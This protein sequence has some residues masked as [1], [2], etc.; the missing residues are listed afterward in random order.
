MFK[1][2][3]SAL[4]SLILLLC[5]VPTAG[6][7]A[8]DANGLAVTDNGVYTVA[9]FAEMPQTIEA[10]IK[11]TAAQGTRV[12][13]LLGSWYYPSDNF[14]D[15]SVNEAGNPYVH[16]RKNSSFAEE[17][18]VFSNVSVETGEWLILKIAAD[19]A[20]GQVHCYVNGE[21]KQ[22]LTT[23][24]AAAFPIAAGMSIGNNLR[25]GNGYNWRGE[26][27]SLTVSGANS[28]LAHYDL[29]GAVE[30]DT[31][32]DTVAGN[33]A[34]WEQKWMDT[35]AAVGEYD[36][37]MAIV[38][39][40]QTITLKY[41]ESLSKVYSYIKDT[42]TEKKLAYAF[43]LGDLTDTTSGVTR[44]WQS[45]TAAMNILG[46]VV[47]HTIV[48]GNHDNEAFYDQYV[49]ADVY[50]D[51]VVTKD[52][53]MKNYYREIT[54]GGT[55]YL[56]LTLDWRPDAQEQAWAAD[57]I[58]QHPHHRVIVSTHSFTE[59]TG[60]INNAG[61]TG[62]GT[63]I[64][65]NIVTKYPNVALVISG[66]AAT[67][68]VVVRTVKAENGN[69]VTHIL[70][71]AQDVDQ[72]IDG[73]AG[74]V[75]YLYF[76]NGGKDV[77]VEYYSPLRNQY[78][79]AKNQ[80]SF[81]LDLP[82]DENIPALSVSD[83]NRVEEKAFTFTPA[84]LSPYSGGKYTASNATY[85]TF[86]ETET[87]II[88]AIES[89]FH[90]YY[91]REG[92]VYTQRD[93]FTN[94]DSDG[95]TRW[96]LLWNELL[97]RKVSAAGG[98]QL[99]RKVDSLV[100]INSLGQE[101]VATDFKT[102]FSARLEDE[103]KGL[104]I[105]GFRQQT[106]GK[107]TNGY[108]KMCTT[109]AFVAIG[110]KGFTVAGGEDIVAKN[111]GDST[112]DMYNHL[113]IS[114]DDPATE[115]VEM[116]P[117]GIAVTV[118]VHGTSCDVTFYDAY[119][120]TIPLYTYTDLAV[121]FT[122]AGTFAYSVS[123]QQNSIGAVSLEIYDQ[124]GN[125]I[126]MATPSANDDKSVLR[127]YGGDILV[128]AEETNDGYLY[129]LTVDAIDGYRLNTD[130]FYLE[131]AT[132]KVVPTRTGRNTFTVLSQTGGTVTAQFEKGADAPALQAE[133]SDETETFHFSAAGLS[134]Y[135]GDKYTAVNKQYYTF[136]ET[137]TDIVNA[138][139]SKF[140]LYY[141]RESV[142]YTQ[143]DLFT[144]GDTEASRW[145]LLYN[146]YLQRTSSKTSGE[147]FRKIDSLVPL[148]SLG[149]EI[150]LQNFETTYNARFESDT[151]GAIILGFRQ[152]T[153][154][155]FVTGYY[156]MPQS[157]A[158]VAIGRS[159]ITIAG[160]SEIVA[161]SGGTSANDMYNHFET[162][163]DDP[164][165]E[166]VEMLPKD[167]KVKV[168]AV[169][170]SVK[171]W[172]YPQ[173]QTEAVYYEET[174]VPYTTAGTLA[175]AVSAVGHD[176][177]EISLTKLDENGKAVDI[178]VNE[179][180]NAFDLIYRG[181]T[182]SYTVA[183][184]E[185]EGEFAY[186]LDV[187]PNEGYALQAGSL[188]VTDADGNTVVPTRVGFREAGD[189]TQYTFTAT[190]EGVVSATFVKPTVDTPNIGNIGTSVNETLMGVRFVSRAAVTVDGANAYMTIDGETC[191][192]TDFGMLIGLAS[193]I[194]D[195]DLTVALTETNRYVK[196]LSV[197]QTGIYYDVW[198][199]G[200]DMSVCIAGVDKVDGG[201]DLEITAR[202]YVT[203]MI[204][205]V[206]TTLYAAP[207]TST[208]N[209]NK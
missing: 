15:I 158:F 155:R 14:M 115:A 142:L 26:I 162:S 105:L 81:S 114:F 64:F 194:G 85:Y 125:V 55:D 18:L 39:D 134:P 163:F 204:D 140:H 151:Y 61:V 13:T 94:G 195:N 143:R 183:E 101:I 65:N 71:D 74:L 209:S 145:I 72:P 82:W 111:G 170:T 107:Y 44:E 56:M 129:T 38:G 178:A 147:I 135:S 22:S 57:V 33:N 63:D 190:T 16:W 9:P 188:Y 197:K 153:P 3:V 117:K 174:Q 60:E 118:E 159:G 160:G 43:T 119:D 133:P 132:G 97:Q 89:K 150:K 123:D 131:D 122:A 1:K 5:A 110:R 120:R 20:N 32:V 21:L 90:L 68:D 70:V 126:D 171:V 141:N 91:D 29:A 112:T 12:G 83:E 42:A 4:L 137:E 179:A 138:I 182:L 53:T 202:A 8:A 76:S 124:N 167:I 165:T 98:H 198:D 144:N 152:Q 35:R 154:G 75:A 206:E 7:F 2:T 187:K 164:T 113:A 148:N 51:G 146:A 58:E 41:P 199:T 208:Y 173:G 203:V 205:G 103:D 161:K 139:E 201:A 106:P 66:H 69:A 88:A 6:V 62:D 99:F 207:F 87:D 28:T 50:G 34:V 92:A 121:P 156:K 157:Q 166:E 189:G 27:R 95:E 185:N 78:Y 149:E 100:P 25:Q 175:Y 191:T 186:T 46:G 80:F 181:G 109:H 200:V 59:T 168:R 96:I 73:G 196:K 108:Y 36:Y 104:A 23:A 79:K 54:I 128:D 10:E 116:L 30:G 172:I 48:R 84:G 24:Y 40:P 93:L 77:E 177:G 180:E 184:T 127:F 102:T 52:G 130:N 37:A 47:P 136:P 31:L 17:K 11:L 176:I 19:F 193:T 67:E 169:G 86:P 45:I 192:V 49:T